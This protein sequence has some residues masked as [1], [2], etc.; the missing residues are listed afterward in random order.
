ML[1]S[2]LPLLL[3][4]PSLFVVVGLIMILLELFIGIETGF[5]LVLIG[6]VLVVS[7]LVGWLVGSHVLSLILAIALS[8]FYIFYGR[9]LIKNKFTIHPHSSNVDKLIGQ[10]GVVIQA[11]TPLQAGLIK[12]D[13][14]SW[15]ARSDQPIAAGETIRII[16]INGVTAVVTK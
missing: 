15:R 9:S 16:A 6:S 7:G 8:I 11:I 2:L 4:V 14:E 13:D 1:D 5:D 3:F 10:T 12:V